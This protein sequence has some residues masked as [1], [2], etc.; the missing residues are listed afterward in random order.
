MP[1]PLVALAI[2]FALVIGA[3]A[4]LLYRADRQRVQE[5]MAA[6][7]AAPA[8]EEPAPS[9]PEAKPAESAA[10]APAPAPATEAPAAG[11]AAPETEPA[12]SA[13]SRLPTAPGEAPAAAPA[14]PA[15]QSRGERYAPGSCNRRAPAAAEPGRGRDRIGGSNQPSG[16]A[17]GAR[18]KKRLAAPRCRRAHRQASRSN[19]CAT[20]E[21][22][23]QP[24]AQGTT[25]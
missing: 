7:S 5:E 9:P 2:I 15:T 4:V 6:R 16:Q 13:A 23:A 10:T 21:A 19:E 18:E 12:E 11:A 24:S 8:V 22:P 1:R 3:A 20:T 17:C 14:A 25:R